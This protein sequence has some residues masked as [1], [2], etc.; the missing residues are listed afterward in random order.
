MENRRR[1][2]RKRPA[3]LRTDS[4]IIWHP[5]QWETYYETPKNSYCMFRKSVVLSEM[6]QEGMLRIFADSRYM[7]WIN[8]QYAAR[9]PAR[10]DPDFQYY[11]VIDIQ[12]FLK[13]GKNTIAVLVVYYGYGTGHSISRIPALFVE[14]S[15]KD[16]ESQI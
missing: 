14:G 11:D 2:V 9:G 13:K 16:A 8:G 5:S 4:S 12:P 3:V 1:F 6:P 10:S 15:V 7:L